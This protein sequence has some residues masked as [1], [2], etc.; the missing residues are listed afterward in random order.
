[1][2]K[3]NLRTTKK[4]SLVCDEGQ[5]G[6]A[7]EIPVDR[8]IFHEGMAAGDPV[9]L[10]EGVVEIRVQSISPNKIEAEVVHGGTVKESTGIYSPGIPLYGTALTNKDITLLEL[11]A[12]QDIDFI[13]LTYVTDGQD[14]VEAKSRL[15]KLGK[16]ISII[17]KI[18]RVEAI[19]RLESILEQADAIMLRRGDLGTQLEVSQVP[20]VQKDILRKAGLAGVP[21]IIA[22]QMLGSM[23]SSPRPT[24]AEASDASN[25]V[26]DGAD[27]VLLSSETAIGR[28]PVQAADILSRIIK[29]TEKEGL[30]FWRH[31]TTSAVDFPH[32]T[33]RMACHAAA[34]T[35]AK[36]IACFTESGRTAMLVAENRPAVP[37]IA[38]CAHHI[39]RRK[40]SIAWGVQTDALEAPSEVEIMTSRV[41][42]RLTENKVAEHGDQIVIVYGAPVGKRGSTNSVRLHVVGQTI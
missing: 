41:E 22:T 10:A 11:V 8:A 17:A 18:D 28:Y 3:S 39:T 25:T 21:A 1:M 37:I 5:T 6:T 7:T 36:L 24:R 2:V 29:E 9:E 19:G 30:P 13:A 33:A 4:I 31:S 20:Q 26:A 32:A 34:Q 38:Y 35:E 42:Q 14:I 12:K 16:D 15:E 27:G 23:V 40:L